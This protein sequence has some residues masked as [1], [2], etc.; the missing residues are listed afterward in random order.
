A[1][2]R[3]SLIDLTPDTIGMHRI[4]QTVIRARLTHAEE[5]DLAR[6]AGELVWSAFPR[7]GWEVT[8]WPECA[9]L[10]PHAL[11]VC[12]HAQRLHIAG[13]QTGRLMNR[14]ASYLYERGH[15][16]Q[17]LP[18]ANGCITVTEAAQGPDHLHT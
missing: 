7:E 3:Y 11:S 1:A 10:L 2:A 16:R 6:A 4:V 12:E 13:W 9:R 8:N 18:V 15:Y 17:A 5:S 14:A